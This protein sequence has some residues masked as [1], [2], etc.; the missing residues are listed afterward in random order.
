MISLVL[1]TYNGEKYIKEQLDSIK[2]QTRVP[3]EV[4][5]FDDRS[6]DSTVEM[7]ENYIKE[8]KLDTWHFFQNKENKGYSLNFTDAM[9]QC[10]GDIIFLADQDDIWFTDKIENMANIMENHSEIDL[11][12]SDIEPFY[13]GEA[14]QKVNFEK[15]IS[16]KTLIKIKKKDKWIKP[17]RPGCSMCFRRSMLEEYNKIWF[18]EYPHDCLLWGL[19]VLNG[20]AFYYNKVTI[21]FR[22]H[23]TNASSR[24]GYKKDYRI[25]VVKKETNFIQKMIE[26]QKDKGNKNINQMLKKQLDLYVRRINTLEN[27]NVMKAILLVTKLAYYGRKRF[28]LTDLYYCMKG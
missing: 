12:T 16:K 27:R 22:R 7:V 6:K 11:L 20:K 19:A 25:S 21:K 13:I 3:D 18:K 1:T 9:N 17:I 2:D 28:W 26:Y 14:P 4:L 10:K 24:G 15:I 23:D 8:N 5:I